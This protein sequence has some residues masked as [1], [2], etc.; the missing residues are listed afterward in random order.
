[1]A[2]LVYTKGPF[3]QYV[4]D[5]NYIVGYTGPAVALDAITVNNG[6]VNAGE[7]VPVPEALPPTG[8]NPFALA[9]YNALLGVGLSEAEARSI[10]G[11]SE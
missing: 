7:Y 2:T 11:Y 6:W 4:R 10:S 8:S 5:G 9:K 3:R 1:M